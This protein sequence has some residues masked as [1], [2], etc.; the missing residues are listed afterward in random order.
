MRTKLFWEGHDRTAREIIPSL[1]YNL[2]T[3]ENLT[4]FFY[5]D[6]TFAQIPDRIYKFTCNFMQRMIG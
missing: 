4:R 1:D 6:K 3:P 2:S 5:K